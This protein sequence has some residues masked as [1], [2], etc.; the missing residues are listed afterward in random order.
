MYRNE[1]VWQIIDEDILGKEEEFLHDNHNKTHGITT[2]IK[3]A[4]LPK[5]ARKSKYIDMHNIDEFRI[6]DNFQ[7]YLRQLKNKIISKIKKGNC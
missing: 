4:K 7:L 6:G 5:K 2:I 1:G 3:E